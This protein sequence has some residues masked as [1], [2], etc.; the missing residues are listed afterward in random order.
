[1]RRAR[2]GSSPRTCSAPSRRATWRGGSFAGID[3]REHGSRNLGATN[4]YR[5]LGWRY[6]IPVGPVRRGQGV[7]PGAGVRAAGVARR[8]CSRSCAASWRSLGHVFSVFVRIQG[9]EGRRDRGRRHARSHAGGARRRRRGVGVLVVF[10][11]ATCRSGASR[12]R[13]CFR[14]PC[15]LLEPPDAARR[16]CGSTSRVAAA[17][18]WLH[19]RQH[20]APAQRAPRTASAAARRRR[21]S[22]SDV[23]VLGAGSWGTTLANLLAAKGDDGAALGLRGRG[24]RRRSTASHENPVF[25]RACGSPPALRAFADPAEAVRGAGSIVS[26]PPSHAVRAVRRPG[27]AVRWRRARW[28]SAPPRASRPTRWR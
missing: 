17:I 4:L 1:M 6:A 22:V 5:V 9:R 23:A 3:L 7:D 11:P 12:P 8:S 21:A 24:G 27:R 28:W 18:I 19:R 10:S 15:M 16:S 25:L 20:P 26:A 14:S 13:P 2:P